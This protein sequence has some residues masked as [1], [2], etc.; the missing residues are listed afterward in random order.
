MRSFYNTKFK[1]TD[2]DNSN[3]NWRFSKAYME[4]KVKNLGVIFDSSLSSEH[5]IKSLC[6][7]LNGTL[8]YLNRV[9]NTL[10]WSKVQDTPNK[11]SYLLLSKQKC[12]NFAAKVARHGKFLKRDHI[13]TLLRDLMCHLY[14]SV[15]KWFNYKYVHIIKPNVL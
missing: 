12:I 13:I 3:N 8:S 6:S 9:K 5:H 10:K 2:W 14:F 1:K 15:Y 7:W 11:C 4:E